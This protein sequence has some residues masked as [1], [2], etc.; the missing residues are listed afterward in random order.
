MN[1]QVMAYKRVIWSDSRVRGGAGGGDGG[2]LQC[3]C[4]GLR[5]W[6]AVDGTG[7]EI[8]RATCWPARAVALEKGKHFLSF[9]PRLDFLFCSWSPISIFAGF[10]S[11]GMV[12]TPE[13]AYR[14]RH[15]K[16][17][18]EASRSRTSNAASP[19][20]T[21]LMNSIVS[22]RVLARAVSFPKK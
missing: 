11:A 7:G 9:S 17:S 4:W 5:R 1:R 10:L 21:G 18:R 15:Y 20:S 2:C 3:S 8:R 16:S 13:M 14:R 19:S 12:F 22:S 6:A